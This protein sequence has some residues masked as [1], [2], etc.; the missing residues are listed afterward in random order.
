MNCIF[1][2]LCCVCLLAMAL[3]LPAARARAQEIPSG[4]TP[5][6]PMQSAERPEA[7]SKAGK[8]RKG[9]KQDLKLAD[10]VVAIQ[11]N[12]LSR[13]HTELGQA[14]ELLSK[15]YKTTLREHAKAIANKRMAESDD[16]K[17]KEIYALQ[18]TEANRRNEAAAKLKG[19]IDKYWA[20]RDDKQFKQ[21]LADSMFRLGE[22]HRET[23]EYKLQLNDRNRVEYARQYELG[24]R[25][26]PPSQGSV[27]YKEAMEL[28]SNLINAFPEYKYRDL[29]IYMLGWYVRESDL[30]LDPINPE[31]GDSKFVASNKI[32]QRLVDS[33]KDSGY[34]INAL[35]LMGLNYYDEGTKNEVAEAMPKAIEVFE[36]IKALTEANNPDMFQE[37]LYR[38]GFCHFRS[39]NFP[40]AIRSFVALLD[41]VDDGRLEGVKNRL[42][43]AEET[44]EAVVEGFFDEDWNGDGFKDTD[45]GPERAL[46]FLDMRR[47]YT[48]DILRRYG[49]ELADGGNFQSWRGAAL[50][51]RRLLD[52]FP[53]DKEAPTV[54]VKLIECLDNMSVDPSVAENE[55]TNYFQQAMA[56]RRR[57]TEL[58]GYGSAW[59]KL[60][61]N[62]ATA[63]QAASRMLAENLVKRSMGLTDD[64]EKARA[65]G[66][67]RQAIFLYNQVI[68]SYK[69]MIAQFPYSN[70]HMFFRLLIAETYRDGTREFDVA[71]REFESIRD[72]D[73]DENNYEAEAGVKAVLSWQKHIELLA[74]NRPDGEIPADIFSQDAAKTLATVSPPADDDLLQMNTVLPLEVPPILSKWISAVEAA[75]I[76]GY[77]GETERQANGVRLIMAGKIFFRYGQLDKAREYYVRALKLYSTDKAL[78]GFAYRELLRTYVLVQD[79]DKTKQIGEIAIAQGAYDAEALATTLGSM[80][81]KRLVAR[82]TKQNRLYE[83]A[84]QALAD[85]DEKRARQLF[86]AAAWELER[87]VDENPDY[88]EADKAL[89]RAAVAFDKSKLYE[90][91]AKLYARLVNEGRFR[92]SP[93]REEALQRMAFNYEQFFD[94]DQAIAAKIRYV[95]EYED[96]DAARQYALSVAILLENNLEYTRA[97]EYIGEYL[98]KYKRDPN[99]AVLKF[100]IGGFYEKA[101]DIISAKAAYKRFIDAFEGVRGAFP[102]VMMAYMKLGRWAEQEGNRSEAAKMYK[103]VQQV[104]A[105]ANLA[106][107]QLEGDDWEAAGLAAEA[108]FKLADQRMEEIRRLPSKPPEGSNHITFIRKRFEVTASINADFGKVL[109]FTEDYLLPDWG[110]AVRYRLGKNLMGFAD[111]VRQLE[112]PENIDVEAFETERDTLVKE[113]EARAWEDFETAAKYAQRFRVIGEWPQKVLEELNKNSAYREKYPYYRELKQHRV[114]KP[115]F[116]SIGAQ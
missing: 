29:A 23:V 56:E 88:V 96:S 12:P 79:F 62:D 75:S 42:G 67:E 97:A 78:A 22:I 35:Y 34:F 25:P 53:L 112:A 107:G 110:V 61:Q 58:Y 103:K 105:K 91:G 99:A 108:G 89:I 1:G 82:F 77:G 24:I 6:D 76:M 87:L 48:K 20:F 86:S 26:L 92:E 10:P 19:F 38:L 68:Q 114:D 101:G 109:N 71:A 74:A 3:A 104:F 80:G 60:Y 13:V 54:H 106:K 5:P 50:V 94:I 11:N 115:V 8:K 85:N 16:N 31:S 21:L 40:L 95:K 116:D 57:L 83:E 27:D 45:V 32:L 14:Y 52:S 47:P 49:E 46:G 28:Y 33:H 69:E 43:I 66:D 39:F 37:A 100:S 4:I 93:Y 90:K 18:E 2:R 98:D 36:R 9:A 102:R 41:F 44:V 51:L 64:A 73:V 84:E 7:K 113:A 30:D 15:E 72:M 55:R 111:A 59:A 70:R 17:N 63:S 81:K 65:N